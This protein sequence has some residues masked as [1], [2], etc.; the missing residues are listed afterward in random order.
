MCFK[1]IS[2]L[3]NVIR[4]NTDHTDETDIHFNIKSFMKILFVYFSKKQMCETADQAIEFINGLKYRNQ[5][6]QPNL[7]VNDHTR[8]LLQQAFRQEWQT[9]EH[10]RDY[11]WL[12]GK[13]YAGIPSKQVF[14]YL[15]IATT[16]CGNTRIYG[17]KPLADTVEEHDRIVKE[18][19][20]AA[21]KVQQEKREAAVQKRLGELYEQR[22][23][24]YRVQLD[25]KLMVFNNHGNDYIADTTFEGDI[26][27]TCGADAYNKAV[28]HLC[29]GP[30]EVITYH[31]NI[32]ALQSW[33]DM[34]SYGYEFLFLGVKTD[35]GYSVEKWEE[36]KANG[37]I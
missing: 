20:E 5:E 14:G 22:K 7:V 28:K 10:G 37:E 25:I 16:G 24:W 27:A 4:T 2:Y 30:E 15:E 13:D 26:I 1:K 33:S 6:N 12:G 8:E 34:T 29:D 36:A 17:Y 11:I 32:S 9:N 31:G 18:R 21:A 23:G 19:D 35:D 3:C